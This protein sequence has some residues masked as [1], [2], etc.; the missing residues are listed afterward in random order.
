MSHTLGRI[1]I[2]CGDASSRGILGC[3]ASPTWLGRA[4]NFLFSQILFPDTC[5]VCDA[6]L[7]EAGRVPVCPACL[8]SVTPLAAEYFCAACQ[9]PFASPFPLDEH[10][11]CGLCRRA[12]RGFDRCYSYGFY[13]GTLARLIQL[14]KYERIEP[15][16]PILGGLLSQS[17]PRDIAFDAIVPMPM[18]WTRRYVR[19]FNQAQLLAGDLSRRTGIPLLDAL[20]RTRVTRAQVGLSDHHRRRNVA[21]AFAVRRSGRLE[22][23]HLLLIDDVLTTG[24][25]AAACA[26]ALKKAGAARVTVLTL[27]R[28]DR[29]LAPSV[30]LGRD[31]PLRAQSNTA[32]GC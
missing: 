4:W 11:L 27:A 28:A 24:A 31:E 9:A 26:A 30:P 25:T 17:L 6:S 13:E 22:G 19:G 8:A 18:H 29:R 1:P 3:D 14:L 12:A 15:L 5:R 32:G 16:A 20:R 23:S 10:Q 2:G 21:G 7:T